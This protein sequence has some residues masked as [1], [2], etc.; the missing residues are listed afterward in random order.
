MDVSPLRDLFTEI[1]SD[2][3][4]IVLVQTVNKNHMFFGR[5]P[6]S[7]IVKETPL[8]DKLTSLLHMFHNFKK[9][10]CSECGVM[11]RLLPDGEVS[12]HGK[13]RNGTISTFFREVDLRNP[14]VNFVLLMIACKYT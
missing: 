7:E 6:M 8:C 2:E 11:A 4:W 13:C 3:E 10:E 9:I 5:K 1:T 12:K 14:L